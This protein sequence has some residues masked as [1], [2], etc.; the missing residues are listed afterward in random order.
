MAIGSRYL[1]AGAAMLALMGSAVAANCLGNAIFAQ[2]TFPDVPPDY[3][4]TP[5]IQVLA[6]EGIVTGYPDGTFRPQ[7]QVEREEF[8]AIVRQAFD[9]GQE[10]EIPSASTFEDVPQGYWAEVPIEEAYETGFMNKTAENAFSPEQ[11]LSKVEAIVALTRGLEATYATPNPTTQSAA[12]PGKKNRLASNKL[13]FPL[14]S[15]AMM[16][17]FVQAAPAPSP[18]GNTSQAAIQEPNS[19]V[20]SASEVVQFY[21]KDAEKIPQDAVEDVAAATKRGMVVDYPDRNYLE[22]GQPLNR[23]TAAALVHQSLVSIGKLQPIAEDQ[24]VSQY[25]VGPFS[26]EELASQLRKSN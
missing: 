3:W 6:R 23:G 19:A 24:E 2:E 4:A 5:F 8:A 16:L 11:P 22:P 12:Q 26:N 21:Y 13:A 17:P 10:R 15:T 18:V 9:R 25:I 7:Q 1:S 20:P 14:A